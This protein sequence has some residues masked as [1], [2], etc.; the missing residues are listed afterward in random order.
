MGC[1]EGEGGGLGK[2][3]KPNRAEGEGGG[4]GKSEK[5]NGAEGGEGG[6]GKSERPNGGAGGM[7]KGRWR[8]GEGYMV[9]SS[10][11]ERAEYST[12]WRALRT[13]ATF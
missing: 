3:E 7:D 2:S 13:L 8:V 11:W 9:R 1:L 12:S 6:L 10:S 5:P 4:L